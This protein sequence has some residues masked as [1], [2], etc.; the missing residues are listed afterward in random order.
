MPELYRST[1]KASS[2]WN[3]RR[4]Y[5]K[6]KSPTFCTDCWAHWP[7]RATA[8][9]IV[10]MRS[11]G[12]AGRTHRETA[13]GQ[14]GNFFYWQREHEMS[15]RIQPTDFREF[16]DGQQLQL[17]QNTEKSSQVTLKRDNLK[18]IKISR[19]GN[20][21]MLWETAEH[22]SIR[23]FSALVHDIVTELALYLFSSTPC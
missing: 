11:T 22:W 8:E 16:S 14:V 12:G 18:A 10:P 7:H 6:V 13:G 5:S 9:R 19:I 2:E 4:E 20:L 21:L 17:N 15:I 23:V 1:G 3:P